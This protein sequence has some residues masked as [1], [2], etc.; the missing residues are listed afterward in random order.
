MRRFIV[1][2]A[3]MAAA[4]EV[5]EP[6]AHSGSTVQPNKG[7]PARPQGQPEVSRNPRTDA[8]GKT[9]GST[10]APTRQGTG[11]TGAATAS[12]PGP[13]GGPQV[14]PAN[15]DV[16][17]R[18]P[19][20][21]TIEHTFR[22]PENEGRQAERHLVSQCRRVVGCRVA[23]SD[24]RLLDDNDIVG[25]LTLELPRASA[26][27]FDDL[28]TAARGQGEIVHSVVRDAEEVGTPSAK[29]GTE[30]ENV[31]LLFH[32]VDPRSGF[33]RAMD[34][35][36]TNSAA[37]SIIL[38]VFLGSIAP[39]L[40]LAWLLWKLHQWRLRRKE[41]LTTRKSEANVPA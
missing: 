3:L 7:G 6:P 5:A 17:S 13:G 12:A 37:A 39:W 30:P 35:I 34:R 22:P 20:V 4:C 25:D 19:P 29:V 33:R 1:I 23:A 21:A 11:S 38:F 9:E 24:I 8:A 10:E 40:L 41:A 16:S 31:R 2:V 26:Q 27:A 18:Q 15:P 14:Q 32:F 36:W 28:A